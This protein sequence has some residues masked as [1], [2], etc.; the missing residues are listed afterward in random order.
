MQLYSGEEEQGPQIRDPFS[1][2]STSFSLRITVRICRGGGAGTP[3]Y[4]TDLFLTM[5]SASNWQDRTFEDR[6]YVGIFDVVHS[7]LI[8]CQLC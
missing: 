4:F 5:Q 8:S 1:W 7:L 3:I 2:N 6:N